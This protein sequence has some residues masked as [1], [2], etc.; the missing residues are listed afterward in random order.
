MKVKGKRQKESG[1]YR[2][3]QKEREIK[4]EKETE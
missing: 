4:W 1:R 3:E 2:E